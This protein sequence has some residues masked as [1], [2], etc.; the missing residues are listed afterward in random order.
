MSVSP[1]LEINPRVAAMKPSATLAMTA[2]AME[3]R[4]QGKPVIGLSAGEPDFN[5]PVPI[6]DEGVEA[7]REGFTRY[8]NNMGM[9]ELREEIKKK[10]AR[11]NGLD[12][13]IDQILC[14]NGAKQ[15]VAMAVTVLCRPGDEVLIPSPYWVSYP[16]MARFAGGTPVVL[17]TTV[18]SDYRVDADSLEAAIT[19]NTR[20]FILC[21]PSNPT[22]SVYSRKELEA[23]ADVIRRHE[24]V[25]VIA[26]EI[27]EYVL[28]DAEHVSF[29]SLAGMKERTITINGFSKGFAMTG[30]RLGYMAG[31]KEIVK[32][33]AKIQGQFTSA[34]S[35]ITQRAG[36]A[37]LQMDKEKLDDMIQAFRNRRD[38]MLDELS[39]IPG[40]VCPKPEGAFYLFPN[41]SAYLG[42]QTPEGKT[43]KDSEDLCMYLLE[44]HLVALVPGTAFGAPDGMRISYAASR[45]NLEEAIRRIKTGLGALR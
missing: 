37:A 31:P 14:S 19:P 42:K 11:D 44:D 28:F 12:Y 6:A 7:I 20:I 30:W 26:D 13:E 38:Y 5:T 24:Q 3:L 34:P 17:P 8:T 1:K 2:R 23:I 41:V 36:V 18:A 39:K 43:I 15:S 32:T 4:R 10:F 9:P 22:G 25:Y 29:A 27:Y 16:E 33:A 45:E 40:L 35:S 21:S